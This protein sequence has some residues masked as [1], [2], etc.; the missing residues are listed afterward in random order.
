MDDHTQI[1]FNYTTLWAR[2]ESEAFRQFATTVTRRDFLRLMGAG[3][4]AAALLRAGAAA[5][6]HAHPVTLDARLRPAADASTAT[7]PNGI[8]SGDT[9]ATRTV[10]WTRS[11]A[12]GEVVFEVAADETFGTVIARATA[13]ADDPLIPV[14]VVIDG[15]QPGTR[16]IWRV[17]NAAGES[18]VGR[19]VTAAEAGAPRAGLRFGVTGDW[20]GELRPYVGIA[21]APDRDLAFFVQHGDTIYADIPTPDVPAE[22]ATTLSE[23]RRKHAEVYSAAYGV[24]FWAALRAVTSVFVAI[25]DHEVTNDFAGGAPV[26]S[27]AR[28]EGEAGTLLNQTPLY[29]NGLQV[30]REYNPTLAEDY[31]GTGDARMDGRPKL[32]RAQTYGTDAAV[33]VLD[34]RSFRDANLPDIPTI[35]VFNQT[36]L[37][38]YLESFFTPGRTFLGRTQMDDLKRDLLAAH[39]AGVL[40]KFVL[41]PEPIQNMGWLGGNDRIEGVAY[42]RAELLRFIE[43]NAIRNVV[44]VSADV[45]TTFINTLVYQDEPGG[46]MIPTGAFE[47]STGSLGFYPPTGQAIFDGARRFNLVDAETA[48]AYE[49]GDIHVKD[50]LTRALFDRFVNEAQG[51][52]TLGLDNG[53]INLLSSEGEMLLGH[54]FGWTEFDIAA[55]GVLTMTTYGVPAYDYETIQ[56]DPSAILARQPEV[57]NRLVIAPQA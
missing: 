16:Y 27:D 52:P 32:Y 34:T 14:K 30:F 6:A 35:S 22:Q 20:R 54:S 18:L 44:F 29:V 38:A 48:A 49:A 8:A 31:A 15:L 50:A 19:F 12:P 4:A 2:I 37:R 40:W 10:L 7:L 28:F 39:D 23:F 47:I 13:S 51:Y 17:T 36:R 43:E 1:G 53:R 21:N 25:D 46:A 56:A 5:Y 42:E 9:T 57:F 45:H 26:E 24:N 3:A 11:T 41:I 55:D 33:F